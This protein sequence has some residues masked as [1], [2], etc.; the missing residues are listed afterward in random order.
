MRLVRLGLF[1]RSELRRETPS[2]RVARLLRREGCC[3]SEGSEK[4]GEGGEGLGKGVETE[5]RVSGDW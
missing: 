1:V 5:G 2:A 3:G 4:G